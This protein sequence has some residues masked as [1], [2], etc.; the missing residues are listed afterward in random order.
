MDYLYIKLLIVLNL[1]CFSLG[2][3]TQIINYPIDSL[4]TSQ[5]TFLSNPAGLIFNQSFKYSELGFRYSN[6]F[7]EEKT[8]FNF[9][10]SPK[11]M[12]HYNTGAGFQLVGINHEQNLSKNASLEITYDKKNFEGFY[13]NDD[14]DVSEFIARTIIKDSLKRRKLLISYESIGNRISHN[15]GID[16]FEVDDVES[17]FFS[18]ANRSSVSVQLQNAKRT[19][20]A[21]SIKLFL[22]NIFDKQANKSLYLGLQYSSVKN[23]YSDENALNSTYYNNLLGVNNFYTSIFDSIN[24]KNISYKTGYTLK[25]LEGKFNVRMELESDF[26]NLTQTYLDSSSEATSK[27]LIVST[28]SYFNG[29]LIDSN[30]NFRLKYSYNFVGN[31]KGN[32]NV[33]GD[34]T[35]LSDKLFV[36]SVYQKR[37]PDFIYQR[38]SAPYKSYFNNL[39]GEKV[40]NFNITYKLSEIMIAYKFH[41]ISNYTF[42]NQFYNVQQLSS[43]STISELDVLYNKEINKF[44]LRS[45]AHLRISSD[46]I[47]LAPLGIDFSVFYDYSLFKKSLPMRVGLIASYTSSYFADGYM[48]LLNV[49][50]FQDDFLVENYPLIDFYLDVHLNKAILYLKVDH[51]N[52][53]LTTDRVSFTIPHYAITDRIIKFGVV[54]HFEN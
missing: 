48:P 36:K 51:I 35:L 19:D 40:F 17:D 41:R 54:W 11:T 5:Y 27:N 4:R 28:N 23:Q 22:E 29:E 47:N 16:P 44:D 30:K 52:Q 43:S 31:N 18:I 13:T 2:C 25:V 46:S 53:G 50:Y 6:F 49:R 1:V 32:F 33:T 45:S 26:F 10:E 9:Y 3:F 14:A 37:Q 7:L 24:F 8:S 38:N 21:K 34:Y 39:K 42:F 15:S 20:K 12:I